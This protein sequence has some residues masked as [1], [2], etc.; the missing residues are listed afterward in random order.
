MA[1]FE[2]AADVLVDDARGVGYNDYKI[3]LVRRTLMATLCEAT[4]ISA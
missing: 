2:K 1:L 3:P 4:E